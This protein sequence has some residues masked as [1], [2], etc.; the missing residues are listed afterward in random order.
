VHGRSIATLL[1]GRLAL[2]ALATGL[3][4]AVL[5]VLLRAAAD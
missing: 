2:I 3:I 4:L 5:P 1:L